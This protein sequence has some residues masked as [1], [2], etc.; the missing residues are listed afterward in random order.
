MDKDN[1]MQDGKHNNN[2]YHNNNDNNICLYHKF[3]SYKLLIYAT[4]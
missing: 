3:I 2:N 1:I 4:N